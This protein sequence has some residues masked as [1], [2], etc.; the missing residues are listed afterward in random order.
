MVFIRW[1]L[2]FKRIRLSDRLVKRKRLA[3]FK[4]QH[5]LSF[6]VPSTG[7][8]GPSKM[9]RPSF[10]NVPR[11]TKPVTTHII[12]INTNVS[13]TKSVSFHP[14]I[15]QDEHVSTCVRRVLKLQSF[16]SST[17]FKIVNQTLIT[18]PIHRIR[19]SNLNHSESE[20]FWITPKL[21]A[22]DGQF[23]SHFFTYSSAD[24]LKKLWTY[25][26]SQTPI[27]STNQSFNP[28]RASRA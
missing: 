26:N 19:S 27:R 9:E 3:E 4:R 11:D 6:E 14:S 16:L 28:L 17:S 25:S 1:S 2:I 24:F 5:L 23:L 22:K 7:E 8:I 13:P 18:K 21:N 12:P 10:W 20:S 15:F